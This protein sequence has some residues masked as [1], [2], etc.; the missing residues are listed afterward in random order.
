M[1][2]WNEGYFTSSTYTY[3]YYRELSPVFQRFCLL[4]RGYAVPELRSDSNYCELGYGQGVSIN[5]HAAA[6]PG[7]YFGTDFN[8]A[9]AAHANELRQAFNGDAKFFDD[10]FEQMLERNDLP[11]FDSISLHGIWSW[12]SKE[13]QNHITEFARRFLKPGGM[14]YN[15]YNC[16][17]G[18]APKSPLREMMILYDQFVGRNQSN[19]FN[20][21][22]GALK[23][24]EN[25]LE[26]KPIYANQV[27]GLANIL[28]EIKKHDHNYLAHE[29]F[30]R[31][32]ICMYFSE[33]A[34]ILQ[35]AKLDFA[36]TM[37]PADAVD[38]MNLSQDAINFLN[39][40]ENKIMKEQ[41]RDYFVNQ[42]FRKDIYV[43]GARQLAAAERNKKLLDMKFVLMTADEI[44]TEFNTALGKVTFQNPDFPAIMEHL[45]AD[46]YRPKKFMDLLQKKPN[47][48]IANIEQAIIVLT[49][50]GNLM[51][52]QDDAAVKLVKGK[53]D[54]LNNYLCSSAEA[55]DKVNFLASPVLGG[56][57]SLGRFEQVFVSLY[58]NSKRDADSLAKEAWRII[59]R[60]NQRLIKEGKTL[61]TAEENIA[62]FKTMAQNFLNK[63]L[64]ILKALQII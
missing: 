35:S 19:T 41:T 31:D 40:I 45:T 27:P 29:Y 14:F 59:E 4:L 38:Q 30:N 13:N 48:P 21:V 18:W 25:L 57:I 63:R 51:P 39:G 44:K 6:V 24:A 32:W 60:Q 1:S 62:E 64:P 10:S 46:N 5:I 52:C 36:C 8:P 9:H 11:Q 3:G 23:F 49:H 26:A 7:H 56:A 16:F 2:D 50:T 12:I 34:E 37:N 42:Q 43:R 53:C 15:S 28:T 54:A 55:S 47:I 22:E 20:R 33:V 58:K 61:N 17:P